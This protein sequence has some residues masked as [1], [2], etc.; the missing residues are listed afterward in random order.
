[1]NS[2]LVVGTY[3]TWVNSAAALPAPQDQTDADAGDIRYPLRTRFDNGVTL[4][5]YSLA[6]DTRQLHGERTA[7]RF[8]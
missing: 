5:G 8:V 7:H 1:M 4:L 2:F 3:T 6:P